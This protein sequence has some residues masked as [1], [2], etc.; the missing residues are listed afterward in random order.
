MCM[1]HVKRIKKSRN[2]V[3]MCFI[4]C[5]Y[6]VKRV[7]MSR[8]PLFHVFMCVLGKRVNLSR[9]PRFYGCLYMC[10]PCC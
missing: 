3:L 9:N 6:H 7:G 2:P 8:S 10:V 1:Y 5:V 4:M